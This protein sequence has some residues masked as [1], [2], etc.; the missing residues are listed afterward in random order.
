MW[1]VQHRPQQPNGIAVQ[2]YGFD[3]QPDDLHLIARNADII[4]EGVVKEVRPAVWPTRD[5]NP[6]ADI[7]DPRRD[8]G[9][10][11]RTPVLLHVERTFKGQ[12]LD[13][14]ILYSFVGGVSGD[15]RVTVAGDDRALV[16]GSRIIV[17]LSAA[18]EGAGSWSRITPW[19]PQMYF[20]VD[21][22]VL[23]GPMKDVSRQSFEQQFGKGVG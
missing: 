11:L 6:S 20:V 22:D 9:E 13:K 23:R 15:Y 21:G 4:V 3:Y 1:F 2:A 19:Y 7:H 8:L 5:G 18:S 16:P 17:F 14:E 10:Q 12:V